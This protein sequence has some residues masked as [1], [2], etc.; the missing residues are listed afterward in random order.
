MENV[1][2]AAPCRTAVGSFGS[3]LKDIPAPM[4]GAAAIKGVL[5]RSGI[6]QKLIDQV[7]M[8]NVLQA[9]QGQNPARQAAF[10]ALISEEIP[11]LTINKVCG[12]GLTAASLAASLIRA[13]DAHC[14]VAG[15]MENMSRVPYYLPEM[16]YG[17]RLGN[18]S[19]VD[20]MIKDGLWDVYNDYHMGITAENIAE[21]LN[22]SR[23]EQDAYAL[24]SQQR[25]SKA[26]A[27]GKFKDEIV[28]V[29]IP[30]KKGEPIIFCE[31][32]YIRDDA[33][34]EQLAKL[35]PAFKKDGTVT[36]GNAS[37]I[38][39]GAAAMLVVSE[40]I[41][42]EQGLKPAAR[43]VAS[44][45]VGVSPA[46]MGL[47]PVPAIKKL[48]EK[49]DMDIND[50][51]LFE[52]NEAFAVQSLG[53]VKQ[54]GLPLEKVNVNGGAIAIGHPIGASG[55]RIAVTLIH[56][57]ARRNVKYGIAAICMGGGMGEA[58]LFELV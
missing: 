10:G 50:I 3:S 56:E 31:D 38:N 6:D 58:V 47:G 5:S 42:K 13:G 22:I 32:E 57:M 54:L 40:K 34:P 33:S 26:K 25:A 1:Y 51:G 7:F 46:L 55:A 15:G 48:L 16:R 41:M 29:E 44:A 8:G 35:R 4:L 53:V 17:G 2:I 30:Q 27:E 20:G 49:V 23:E 39:D 37:G 24:S 36:A 11:A 21:T 18:V 45:T 9:G 52:A 28:P 19:A 43:L 14:I 12:S